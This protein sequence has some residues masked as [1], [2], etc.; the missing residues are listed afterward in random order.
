ML[1]GAPQPYDFSVYLPKKLG[2]SG[3][4]LCLDIDTQASF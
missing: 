4:Y 3:Y 2:T 1:N